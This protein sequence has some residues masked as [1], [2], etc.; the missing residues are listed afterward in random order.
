MPRPPQ[1]GVMPT[2]RTLLS[3]ASLSSAVV[4]FAHLVAPGLLIRAAK[5]GYDTVLDVEF[6][7]GDRTRAR[8]RLLGVLS[9]LAAA[10]GYLLTA[11]ST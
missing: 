11:R 5:W 4:G 7:P 1:V 8:V 3:L 9:L 10:V 6:H 2:A